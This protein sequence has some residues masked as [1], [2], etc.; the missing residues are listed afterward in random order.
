MDFHKDNRKRLEP[1]IQD[2]VYLFRCQ[3]EPIQV[4]YIGLTKATYKFKA[5]TIGSWKL[6]VNLKKQGERS[7]SFS[8][9][10]GVLQR[11]HGL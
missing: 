3:H 4:C 11:G 5:R 8:G 10:A 7:A 1:N 9:S 6:S 2:A